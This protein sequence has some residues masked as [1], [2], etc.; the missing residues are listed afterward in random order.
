MAASI[1][2]MEKRST[3]SNTSTVV[4]TEEIL[5][6]AVVLFLLVR[7]YRTHLKRCGC[8]CA[9]WF[10]RLLLLFFSVCVYVVC[11]CVRACN[12]CLSVAE[13]VVSGLY[14]GESCCLA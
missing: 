10:Y 9:F 5:F 12:R 8:K 2:H 4:I 3:Y 13:A 14:F 11:M 1:K 6:C 7:F